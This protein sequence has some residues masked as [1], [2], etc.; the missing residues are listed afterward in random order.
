MIS[1][2]RRSPIRPIVDWATKSIPLMPPLKY[3]LAS[4]F[5]SADSFA[6][7]LL[8]ASLLPLAWASF[9]WVRTLKS[10]IIA[11]RDS[12]LRCFS[13][14]SLFALAC[15]PQ[16]RIMSNSRSHQ[17]RSLPC[18]WAA[19]SRTLSFDVGDLGVDRLREPV[20]LGLGGR[21]EL[22]QL[23]VDLGGSIPRPVRRRAGLD[24]PHVRVLVGGP[25]AADRGRPVV[26]GRADRPL[27]LVGA[28]L[29]L[30][31]ALGDRGAQP[32]RGLGPDVGDPAQVLVAL[33][34]DRR[35]IRRALDRV[36]LVGDLLVLA[37]LDA[38][39]GLLL[40]LGALLDLAR[41]VDGRCGQLGVDGVALL[42]HGGRLFGDLRLE[43]LVGDARRGR[44]PV[45]LLV[46]LVADGDALRVH[47]GLE[48]RHLLPV[49]ARFH[50]I[51]D[52]LGLGV[53]LPQEARDRVAQQA[54][55]RRVGRRQLRRTL[56][57]DRD[58]GLRGGARNGLAL[59]VGHGLLAPLEL[60]G[61][62]Q[63]VGGLQVLAGELGL[64]VGDPSGGHRRRRSR[65]PSGHRRPAAC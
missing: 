1:G 20:G 7:W 16:S 12:A 11:S 47:V 13:Q 42:E 22:L 59:D 34:L 35:G 60:L 50:A 18:W 46:Q 17:E 58:G 56:V 53:D 32:G 52:V 19:Q 45:Q 10:A 44:D 36:L 26:G 63:S 3:W 27:L 4:R 54:R 43:L 24:H 55:L 15:L 33:L 41:R 62:G 64:E 25:V 49:H 2:T 21:L 57:L 6:N 48:T 39:D 8:T 5:W 23:D 28:A 30:G 40:V 51:A 61:H 31:V 38:A 9:I 65:G 37:R 29:E 14:A